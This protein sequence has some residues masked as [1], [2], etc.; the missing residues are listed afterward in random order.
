MMFPT[1]YLVYSENYLV[2]LLII[3][4]TLVLGLHPRSRVVIDHKSQ[5]TMHYLL[6]I[7]SCVI[8]YH[9]IIELGVPMCIVCLTPSS[10][11][12]LIGRNCEV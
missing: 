1:S 11:K 8:V 4:T 2:S 5:A 9:Y 3:I 7:Y 10:G 12:L 6:H